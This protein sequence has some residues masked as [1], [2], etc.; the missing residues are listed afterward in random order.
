M[1]DT[2]TRVLRLLSLLQTRRSWG[3]AELS[4]RL[5]VAPRTVRRDVGRLRELGYPID[6]TPGV[7]GGYKL[8]AGA[9]L[10]PLLLDD[11]E[12]VAVAIGLRTSAGGTV[13]GIEQTSVRALAKL[14]QVLPSRLR[15]RVDALLTYAVPIAGTG[16]AVD[17]TVLTR[18]AD[19]CRAG[20]LLRFDYRD[21]AGTRS[22]RTVEP[23]RLVYTG[24][25]WY[26]LA[27]DT[28]RRN[29]RSFRVDRIQPR[30]A[31]GTRF[32]PR[33]PP[34]DVANLVTRGAA[35]ALWSYR[36]RVTVHAPAETVAELIPPLAWLVEAVDENQCV[37]DAGA[38]TP[39]LLAV[40]LSGLDVD[41]DVDARAAP[42][43]AE[44]LR[45]LADR[46]T[47]AAG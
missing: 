5:G 16:P 24:R 30:A 15:H 33:E 28:S 11:D 36:A 3:S 26:L 23:H 4:E 25:R 37:L 43:L 27:W 6:A 42:D 14:E 17:A 46:C 19:A 45:T 1:T 44:Q 38:A 20:V 31:T 12:A 10:P 22:V 34:G 47:R 40:Y 29:W 9:A 41:F 35:A 7:S 18:I 2:S 39:H 13:A 21:H 32:I 8:G